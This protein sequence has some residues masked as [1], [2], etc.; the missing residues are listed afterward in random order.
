MNMKRLYFLLV[1]LLAAATTMP[2]SA[3]DVPT[4]LVR[5]KSERTGYYLS[6][7]KA[8]SATTTARNLNTYNQVWVLLPSDN[9]YSLRS[10]NTGEYLQAAY[11][12]PGS[13]KVTLY[14]RKSPNATTS[15]ALYNISSDSGFG[16]SFLN[17]NTSYNL[18]SYSMD[19][20]CDWYI[21]AVTNYTLEDVKQRLLDQSPYAGEL[22]E[23]KYYR[24]ISYYGRAL[25][26]AEVLG[27]DVTTQTVDA[28]EMAQYW[29]LKKVDDDWKL[30]NVLTQRFLLCQSDQSKPYR[31]TTAANVEQ[32]NLNVSFAITPQDDDW[33]YKWT[34]AA[35]GE[36]QG[37]HDAESQS[38]NVVRWSTAAAASVWQ[39][40]EVELSQEDI[41]AAREKLSDLDDIIAEFKELSSRKAVLQKELDSLFVDKQC[42]T[43]R[44]TIATLTDEE[45]AQNIHFA[46]LTDAMKEMVLKVKNNTWQ[47]YTN[48]DY[49]ADYER[50]FR[51]AD[52][53]VYSNNVTMA[54]SS[55]FTMSNVFGRL[56]GPTGIVADKGDIIYIYVSATPSSYAELMLEAVSTEGVAGA[57]PTGTQTPLRAGLNL[58]QFT[59]KKVL[60]VLYQLKETTTA[61]LYMRLN[62][63]NDVTVHIEGGQL[64]GYWDATRG[65]TND[66]WKLLQ[67]DLLKASPYVNLKTQRLVFQMDKDLVV[68]AEPNEMEG[69]MR[70]WD[71][72][73][74]NEDR[75]MGVEDF[76]GKYNNI[77]NAFSGASSYMHATT[78]GTWYSEGT[79]STVMNYQK[80]TNGGGNLWGPSHEIGHNHQGS[81]NVIGTTESSNNM[82]SNINTFESGILN[83]RRYYPSQNFD[84]MASQTPWLQRNIWMTT[85]MF[86][87]LYLYFHAQ[88]HDDNFL[89]NLFRKMRKNPISKWSGPGNGGP[90]SYGKDDYLHLAKMICDVAQ[91]DLSEFFEAYGMFIPVEMLHVEDYANYDV[92]TTQAHIDAAKAYMQKYEKKLGN[93]MFID[94]RIIKK[95]ADPDNIF[96]CVVA[97]DGYKRA[98]EEYPYLMASATATYVGGDYESFTDDA[99]PVTDDWYKLST[100]GKTITFQGSKKYAGHKFYDADGNLLWAT[101]KTSATL[102]AVVLNV[103]MANVKVVTANYDMSDTPCT[104]TKPEDAILDIRTG[105]SAAG[106]EVIDLTG[107]RLQ[108]PTQAGIYIIDGKKVFVR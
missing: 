94:D 38:H 91:A 15:K 24:V 42:T 44:D 88:H 67:K 41:D 104:D 64:N 101:N 74:E 50:F 79:I 72:I 19:A 100:S 36:S 6:T 32:F 85:G 39:F 56:S 60:Y 8:G 10:A 13:G 89:P 93:I 86:F 30:E 21:E 52:Y 1:A 25:Q 90:T 27:G 43:L 22:S 105:E 2:V 98:N 31:T 9:G 45:L 71:K 82:F 7:A 12:T 28:K 29:T 75:Y 103:G 51:V 92:T 34:I 14:I 107:R 62:R 46:A 18:F 96:G 73:V 5:V 53:H 77:W 26:D 81:I 54:N 97:S 33:E 3:Q 87:Q 4:G 20:G 108:K 83:S 78:Y 84:Y 37:L 16:G 76:E 70:L 40:Q 35:P 23:G 65:M 48:G 55:N 95:K 68:A 102:P 63:Y 66:D 47:Q 11:A 69:L 106:H 17:T 58:V 99:T 59:E 49:T 57:N 80:M 61:S